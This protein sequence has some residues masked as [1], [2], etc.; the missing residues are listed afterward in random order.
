V[1]LHVILI[2]SKPEV[3]VLDV[4]RETAEDVRDAYQL[5]GVEA[6]LSDELVLDSDAAARLI[7]KAPEAAI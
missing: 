6:I 1:T 2:P 5:A 4:D 3:H 7:A